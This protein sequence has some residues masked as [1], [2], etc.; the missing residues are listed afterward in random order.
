M[1]AVDCRACSLAI[2]EP[3]SD[4]IKSVSLKWSS[5]QVYSPWNY[6]EVYIVPIAETL[7]HVPGCV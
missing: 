1:R 5:F 7:S 2:C 6:K 3:A 4:Y